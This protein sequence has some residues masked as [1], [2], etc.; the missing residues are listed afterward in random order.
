MI[1]EE[2]EIFAA[3]CKL[4]HLP[5]AMP[6]PHECLAPDCNCYLDELQWPVYDEAKGG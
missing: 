4:S 5:I 1:F 6:V 3:P 2:Q